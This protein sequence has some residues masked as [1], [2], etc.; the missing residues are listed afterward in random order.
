MCRKHAVGRECN[1]RGGP[2]RSQ[3]FVRPARRDAF[4]G[5]FRRPSG[6]ASARRTLLAL[7]ALSPGRQPVRRAARRRGSP[8][9]RRRLLSPLR[10]TVE[11]R[12][13]LLRRSRT[14]GGAREVRQLF[15]GED[16]AA[17]SGRR[18]GSGGSAPLL[19]GSAA[20]RL[21]RRSGTRRANGRTTSTT[22]ASKTRRAR[23]RPTRARPPPRRASRT[24]R[25]SSTGGA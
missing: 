25:A 11:C 2:V 7:H 13:L 24:G 6:A 23:L 3:P 12:R 16:R 22:A 1:R 10:R 17:I 15:A 20:T 5:P 9:A 19:P 8:C 14:G 4:Q 21:S 18:R